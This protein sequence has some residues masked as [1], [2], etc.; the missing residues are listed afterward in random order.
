VTLL[1]DAGT[2]T[3]ALGA[4]TGA[5]LQFATFCHSDSASDV[6]DILRL[7]LLASQ[8]DNHRLPT[9]QRDGEVRG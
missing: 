6:R 7:A 3:A 8:I 4:A 1:D 2:V 5:D 9:T